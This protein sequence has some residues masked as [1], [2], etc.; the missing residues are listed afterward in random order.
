ML[1]L[2]LNFSNQ[3]KELIF[4]QDLFEDGVWVLEFDHKGNCG[5]QLPSTQSQFF[6]AES[7]QWWR[8]QPKKR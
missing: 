6:P 3:E 5:L 1:L 7:C 8:F 4:P 2:S